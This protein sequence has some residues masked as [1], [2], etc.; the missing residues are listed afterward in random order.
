MIGYRFSVSD[1]GSLRLPRQQLAHLLRGEPPP[2]QAAALAGRIVEERLA[3]CCNLLPGVE[4]FYWWSDRLQ[5]DTESLL[6]FKVP[7]A[8]LEAMMARL[9][10]LHPYDV[11][12]ILAVPVGSG[13]PAYLAW[14]AGETGAT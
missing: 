13:L 2:E 6:L 1:P 8:R 3:A 9:K 5:R 12:E 11:P 7:D 4:S 10:A 14:A